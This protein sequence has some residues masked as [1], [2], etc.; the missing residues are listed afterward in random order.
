SLFFFSSRRRHTRSKRDWSSDVCSSDLVLGIINFGD[1]MRCPGI[2][3]GNKVAGLPMPKKL[4]GHTTGGIA[5]SGCLTA[6]ET[7]DFLL[8]CALDGD[9]YAA[10]PVGDDPWHKKTE[11]GADEQLIYDIVQ[12]F[13]GDDIMAI[14]ER[15]AGLIARP[16]AWIVGLVQAI[17]NGLTFAV[18]GPAA[19]HW[20]YGPFVPHMVEWVRE[21]VASVA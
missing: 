17:V 15:V 12:E 11:V 3:N 9:L 13:D 20:C 1:P 19:P 6:D 2:A 16:I 8:S 14:V 10:A 18:A 21:Q 4:D 7:P 5:G